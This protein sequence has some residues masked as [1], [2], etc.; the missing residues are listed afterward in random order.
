MDDDPDTTLIDII[1]VDIATKDGS[2]P[3]QEL[4]YKKQ[5]RS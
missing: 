1:N 5:K 3:N 4:T 2:K